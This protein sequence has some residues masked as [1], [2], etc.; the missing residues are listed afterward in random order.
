MNF[1]CIIL[2][3]LVSLIDDYLQHCRRTRSQSC[4]FCRDTLKRVNS[5]DLWVFTDSR[6]IVD[7]ATVTRENL[8]RLFIYIDK[9]PVVVPDNLFDAYD[10]HLRWLVQPK[11]TISVAFGWSSSSSFAYHKDRNS[12]G[13]KFRSVFFPLLMRRSQPE[14]SLAGGWSWD[15]LIHGVYKLYLKTQFVHACTALKIAYI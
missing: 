6:D 7:M 9:F 1:L 14:L 13:K 15:S 8:R 12:F 10:S 2:H 11:S 4:P 3:L 5:G